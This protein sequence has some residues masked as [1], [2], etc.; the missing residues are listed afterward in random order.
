MHA[1]AG[2]NL[3]PLEGGRNKNRRRAQKP[4]S[5]PGSARA[6]RVH[7]VLD[8]TIPFHAQFSNRSS[9]GVIDYDF[10]MIAE[11]VTRLERLSTP[12]YVL[13]NLD[14]SKWA[15]SLEIRFAHDEIARSAKAVLLNVELEAISKYAFIGFDPGYA[16]SGSCQI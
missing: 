5:L 16:V 2:Y 10:G 11:S 12:L 4:A 6:T 8:V 15:D 13:R 3:C 1:T 14:P 9:R 7:G